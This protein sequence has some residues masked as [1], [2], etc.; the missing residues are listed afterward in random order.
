M[1]EKAESAGWGISEEERR[2]SAMTFRVECDKAIRAPTGKSYKTTGPRRETS[3]IPFHR[4]SLTPHGLQ[5]ME[6]GLPHERRRCRKSTDKPR[7]RIETAVHP[8]SLGELT[9]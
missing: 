3:Q 6:N 8:G 1:R 7:S 2:A 5:S 9:M 4:H